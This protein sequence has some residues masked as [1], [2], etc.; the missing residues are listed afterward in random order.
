M[1]VLIKGVLCAKE[2]G[3]ER[4]TGR[5]QGVN[6]ALGAIFFPPPKPPNMVNFVL[7]C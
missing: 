4:S 1:S 3:R 7:K 2:R 6:T 5:R